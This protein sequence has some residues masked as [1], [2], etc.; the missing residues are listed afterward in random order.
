MS[1][2][3]RCVV[4]SVIL[5]LLV[6]IGAGI[7]IGY[8]LIPGK[9]DDSSDKTT[10]APS[11]GSSAVKGYQE[12]CEE[13]VKLAGTCEPPLP[14]YYIATR[15][16]GN[17]T[18]DGRLNDDAW[19]NVPWTDDFVDIRGAPPMYPAPN[20]ETRVKVIYDDTHIYVA[21]R[22]TEDHVW[23]TYTV[24]DSRV[25]QENAFEIF[26]DV[27]NSM[28]WYKEYEINAL[29][30]TWD[31]ALSRA[32]MDGGDFTNWEGIGEKGVYTDG[33]V[34]NISNPSTFWSTEVSFPFTA[35]NE[36]TTRTHH[37]PRDGEVWFTIFARPEYQTQ[38][39]QSTGQYEQ[40]PGS[41]ASWWS[42]SPIGAVNLHLPSKWGLLYFA[43]QTTETMDDNQFRMAFPD[44][45]VY[46]GL[47]HVF[48][49]LQEFKAARGM[50]VSDEKLIHFDPFIANCYTG[51]EVKLTIEGFTANMAATSNPG[52]VGYI[53]QNRRV[54]FHQ[55]K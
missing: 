24:K 13:Q 52:R 42:W 16:S 6:G 12:E 38:A 2:S 26:F 50:F 11:G 1:Y 33:G 17:L 51:F 54:W 34:N 49:V 40:V 35:L 15:K 46:Y 10:V 29:G 8:F 28:S 27:D 14:R 25:Y 18:V 23:A 30:T 4:G 37:T 9:D 5:M 44:W 19:N 43:N 53:D 48:D 21:T 22:L 55:G 36:N 31:L 41:D 45:N 3:G 47:F 7:A 39:N 20:K 32:Y